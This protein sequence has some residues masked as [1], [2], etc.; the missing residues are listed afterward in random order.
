MKNARKTRN[1]EN[2]PTAKPAPEPLSA[3]PEFQRRGLAREFWDYLMENKVWWM[4]PI[5]L[6]VLLLAIL[7][8]FG[9]TALA[10]L[11]YPLF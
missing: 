10:P 3:A 4:A 1:S 9:G 5:L 2:H 7:L 8:I 11:I 6:M